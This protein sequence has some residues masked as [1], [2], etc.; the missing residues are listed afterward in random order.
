[1]FART[2]RLDAAIWLLIA[3]GTCVLYSAA[4]DFDFINLDDPAYIHGSPLLREGLSLRSLSW[5]LTEY[6]P[7]YWHPATWISYLADVEVFGFGPRG[8]HIT[9]VVLHALTSAFVFLLLQL[10]T[11]RRGPSFVV[12]AIFATHPL[13]VESFA[14]IAE[15]KDV[16][17]GLFFVTSLIAYVKARRGS[18]AGWLITSWLLF[19]V[20]CAAKPMAVTLP[21]VLLLLDYWP[22]SRFSLR[23]KLPFFAVSIATAAITLWA[24]IKVSAVHAGDIIP[25]GLRVANAIVS[26]ASY[27]AKTIWPVDLAVFYPYRYDIKPWAIAACALLLIAVTGAA[28]HLRRAQ[29]HILF[30]WLFF[31][32]TLFPVI[33]LVQAGNQAMADRFMYVPILGLLIAI[34]F[35]ADN[36][37]ARYSA[38]APAFVSIV[39]TIV[40]AI[41]SLHQLS[42]WRDSV[43]LFTRALAVTERNSLAHTCLGLAYADRGDRFAAASQFQRAIVAGVREVDVRGVKRK[44]YGDWIADAYAGL[45]R[46]EQKA[47][48]HERAAR[49]YA[50]A[51]QIRPG[52]TAF[53]DGVTEARLA[54]GDFRASAAYALSESRVS[55]EALDRIGTA[56]L[57]R[58]DE[59]AALTMF[60]EALRR[61]PRAA[62]TRV[63]YAVVLAHRG[64]VPAAM[65]EMEHALRDNPR[66]VEAHVEIALL[67]DRAGKPADARARLRSSLRIDPHTTRRYFASRT[68]SPL[69][70]L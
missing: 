59:R 23:D 54:S 70:A 42:Y 16:L 14:W 24:Q 29:P 21:C 37:A 11:G 63:K 12:G 61:S 69:P 5:A 55:A 18:V 36:F 57:L 33:G 40:L 1:M 8:H 53:H 64:A 51:A 3:A 10:S 41:A 25:I 15:R 9:N 20:A 65:S 66:L 38:P 2:S 44:I 60:S 6:R 30:G 7:V 27:I 62:G 4:A 68:G 17:S 67:L 48:Q 34:V 52:A 45:A 43:T 28:V 19:V 50:I 32:G 31:L 56:Y 47:G 46:I 13:H 22:L 35:T 26:Y 58:G 49:L 39:V